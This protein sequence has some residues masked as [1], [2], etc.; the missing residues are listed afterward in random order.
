MSD[1]DPR[2]GHQVIDPSV[3]HLHPFDP[4]FCGP[5]CKTVDVKVETGICADDQEAGFMNATLQYGGVDYSVAYSIATHIT[6]GGT[7]PEAVALDL[8]Q[9]LSVM[10]AAS[11]LPVT[12]E[13]QVGHAIEPDDYDDDDEEE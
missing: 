13:V 11:P 3:G 1:T 5:G 7:N 12:F 4:T 2:T 10:A 8:T 9:A 6:V